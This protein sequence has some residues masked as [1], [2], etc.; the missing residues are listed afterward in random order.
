MNFLLCL[1]A[2][3][4]F[5]FDKDYIINY[6]NEHQNI[7]NYLFIPWATSFLNKNC[8]KQFSKLWYN[9]A[10]PWIRSTACSNHIKLN[11][12]PDA[13]TNQATMAGWKLQDKSLGL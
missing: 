2:L 9:S 7:L 13:L 5:L 3:Y 10:S 12:N 1:S 11:E 6:S 8:F 4:P